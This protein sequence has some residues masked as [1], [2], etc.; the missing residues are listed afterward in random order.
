MDPTTAVYCA[1]V[2]F[3]AYLVRGIA[4]FGSTLIAVPLL[5]L[6]FPLTLVV[7]LVVLLDYLGSAG[8]GVKNRE[9]IAWRDLLPLVPFT[10]TGV[11]VG[12]LVMDGLDATV[13]QVALGG[14]VL[15]YAVYQL[16]P[17]PDW[18]GSRLVSVPLGFLGGW[19]GALFG[20][21]GP[22]YVTYLTL[23]GL[24]KGVFR[25]SVATNFLIDG[26]M[27]LAGYAALGLYNR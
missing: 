8:Q 7:P 9:L 27:R 24:D 23:R 12:L 1:L 25:A 16:L 13:L 6:V 4:G 26:S 19:V 10:F 11:V 2:L 17:T 15:L 18:H 3:S 14:F 5:A 20:T 21:G 22:F